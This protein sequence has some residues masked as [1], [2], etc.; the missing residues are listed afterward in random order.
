M[1]ENLLI[2]RYDS[3][4]M[5]VCPIC[6]NEGYE[7]DKITV[8][9]HVSEKK[10]PLEDAK[11]YFCENPN[12]EV[13]YFTETSHTILKKED[14][15]TKV[16][17]KEKTSPKPLCYCKQV[18]EEDVLRAIE[19]GAKTVDEVK[20]MTGIGGGGMCKY[21][22]PSGRCCSRSYTSFI[23]KAL[24]N[25]LRDNSHPVILNIK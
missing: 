18:T 20:G 23:E 2:A 16:T 14:V 9:I 10:W 25:K 22:N 7:V 17:F 13:V 6:R 24:K 12:C 3:N 5:A 1:E 4:G 11:Y 19:R 21:T 8:L 15:K